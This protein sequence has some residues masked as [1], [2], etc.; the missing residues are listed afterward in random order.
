MLVGVAH[1]G[2]ERS[3]DAR[4]NHLTA[5]AE[6]LGDKRGHLDQGGGEDVG[7]NQ[8]PVAIDVA[9]TAVDELNAVGEPV[10]MGVG[11]GGVERGGIGIDANGGRHA[12]F[13]SG[14]GEDSRAGSHI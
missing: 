9:G 7:D 2:D 12:H 14:E 4:K 6:A 11:F 3:V 13:Q 1:F 10:A 5:G 8:G